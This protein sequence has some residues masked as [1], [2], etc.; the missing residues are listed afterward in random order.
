M[1]GRVPAAIWRVLPHVGPIVIGLIVGTGAARGSDE[2]VPEEVIVE[3][4]GES[5]QRPYERGTQ[6]DDRIMQTLGAQ[7]FAV[8][9][10]VNLTNDRRD[11]IQVPSARA[12]RNRAAIRGQRGRGKGEHRRGLWGGGRS[13]DRRE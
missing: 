9:G 13:T 11:A 2:G 5:N 1:P 6:W 12:R 8:L 7:V 3:P 4:V 10:E